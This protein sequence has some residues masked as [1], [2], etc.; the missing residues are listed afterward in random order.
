MDIK[1]NEGDRDSGDARGA[2]STSL[3]VNVLP[4]SLQAGNFRVHI[5]GPNEAEHGEA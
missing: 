2:G 3:N 1:G 4:L 5:S